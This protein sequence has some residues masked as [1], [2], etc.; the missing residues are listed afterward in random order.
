M[1]S[2]SFGV[3]PAT[4][5]DYGINQD[6][7]LVIKGLPIGK[8]QIFVESPEVILLCWIEI[9]PVQKRRP[10]FV[11]PEFTV[12]QVKK[13]IEELDQIPIME[14]TLLFQY[15]SGSKVY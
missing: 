1:H 15:E 10:V 14:Q 13:I 11:E 8:V 6:S 4:L 5:E 7:Q 9:D 12:L 3:R 2:R